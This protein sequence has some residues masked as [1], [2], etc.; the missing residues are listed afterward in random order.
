MHYESQKL[1]VKLLINNQFISI[2]SEIC[3]C[4]PLEIKEY[5]VPFNNSWLI[6]SIAETNMNLDLYKEILKDQLILN[7]IHLPQ[8][9]HIYK[10]NQHMKIE[11]YSW[12]S[13]TIQFFL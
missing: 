2:Q 13:N 8:Y 1:I 4:L 3:S 7:P 11:N 6:D 10:V 5:S 9:P 12:I